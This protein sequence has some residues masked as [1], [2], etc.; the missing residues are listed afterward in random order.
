MWRTQLGAA[1]AEPPWLVGHTASICVGGVA[2][3]PVVVAIA[4]VVVVVGSGHSSELHWLSCRGQWVT[5]LRLALAASS[6]WCWWWLAAHMAWS[7]VA[8]YPPPLLLMGHAAWV[9]VCGVP[10]VVVAVAVVEGLIL[11]ASKP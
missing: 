8:D 9:C 6:E 2:V 5:Q 10:P 3:P 4:V 7:C 1:S 11:T